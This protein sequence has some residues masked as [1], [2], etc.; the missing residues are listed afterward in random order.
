[1]INVLP[2]KAQFLFSSVLSWSTGP[3]SCDVLV[4]RVDGHRDRL[5]QVGPVCGD[6]DVDVHGC[7]DTPTHC[8]VTLLLAGSS[9][10]LGQG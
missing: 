1:V 9:V 5:V 7:Q 10:S 4:S 2:P 8:P 6:G 3:P